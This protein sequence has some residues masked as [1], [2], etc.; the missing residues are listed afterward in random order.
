MQTELY[1]L[2]EVVQLVVQVW[3]DAVV[4]C[5]QGNGS[6]LL[7]ASQPEAVGQRSCQRPLLFPVTRIGQAENR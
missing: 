3:C 7:L 4:L 6:A 5:H 2:C 1:P